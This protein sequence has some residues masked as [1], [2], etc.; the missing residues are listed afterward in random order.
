MGPFRLTV[1]ARGGV[2][3]LN[4]S[5]ARE[6]LAEME[7]WGDDCSA[8]SKGLRDDLRAAFNEPMAGR[9]EQA[10]SGQASGCKEDLE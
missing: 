4:E 6:L 5:Q 10:T 7:T 8:A 3:E 1:A 2:V 9:R